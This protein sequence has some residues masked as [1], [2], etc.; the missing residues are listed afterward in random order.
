MTLDLLDLLLIAHF[1]FGKPVPWWL[2]I[3]GVFAGIGTMHHLEAL[4]KRA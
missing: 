3:L 2:W 4:R 1:C